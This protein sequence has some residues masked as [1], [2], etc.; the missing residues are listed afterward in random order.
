[1]KIRLTRWPVEYFGEERPDGFWD[2]TDARGK[3]LGDY[4]SKESCT[5]AAIGKAKGF[6]NFP[7]PDKNL[8]YWEALRNEMMGGYCE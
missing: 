5:N 3:R 2:L 7:K 4:L 6:A 1:M 8:D